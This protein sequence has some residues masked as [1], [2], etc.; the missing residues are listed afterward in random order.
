VKSSTRPP[1]IYRDQRVPAETC[2]NIDNLIFNVYGGIIKY[3][4]Q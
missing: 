2:Q 4:Q 1:I 3:G